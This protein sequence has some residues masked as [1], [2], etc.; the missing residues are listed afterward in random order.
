MSRSQAE[1][2][3]A[4]REIRRRRPD[5]VR[6]SLD[7]PLPLLG[8]VAP[9]LVERTEEEPGSAAASRRSRR[10]DIFADDHISWLLRGPVHGY[11]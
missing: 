6:G 11:V 2:L 4:M 8:P 5:D 9:T 10:D 7:R 3:A 1:A